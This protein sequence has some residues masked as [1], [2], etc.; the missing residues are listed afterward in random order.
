MRRGKRAR[1]LVTGGA[2]YIGSVVARS[3]L[4]QGYEVRVLDALLHGGTA[5]M[6]LYQEER[7]RFVRGDIRSVP[8]VKAALEHI[9]AVVHLAAIVGDPACS[10]D[11][12]L[13]REVNH[14]AALQLFELS[15]A[16]GVGRFIFASTCSNYGRMATS[17][18]Y[19]TEESPLQPVSLYAETKVA[20]EQA[21]LQQGLRSR[22]PVICV[23]R[24]ATVFGLSPRMRFDL[25]VNEFTREL[26]V[27][28]RL[29]IFGE[30]FWRPYIHVCD[31]AQAISLAL[32]AP[33]AVVHG[34]AFNAGDTSQNYQKGTLAELVRSQI[35]GACEIERIH[36]AEDPRDYRVRFDKIAQ[37]LGFQMTRTVTRGVQ[38]VIEA[39]SRGVITDIDHASYRNDGPRNGG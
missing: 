13:A 24:F 11:R 30:Q 21:L 38:E 35:D 28:R 27:R 32:R 4:T 12:A 17:A 6:G 19:L 23:L 36:K 37:H 14:D 9:D 26:L 7:F 16:Q 25:T 29:T 31:A 8:V 22:R 2:G 39:I 5:L 18:T 34:Q 1:I 33:A 10:Q 20:V 15:R 3:L